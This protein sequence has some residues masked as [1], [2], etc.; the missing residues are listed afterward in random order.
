M[1]DQFTNKVKQNARKAV[2]ISVGAVI[3]LSSYGYNPGGVSLRLKTPSFSSTPQ[4]NGLPAGVSWIKQEG[5]YLKVP[6]LSRTNMFNKNGTLAATSSQDLI[7]TSS[8]V[9][10]PMRQ[11][12]ADSY[13]ME[14]EWSMRYEIPTDDL[15]LEN[16]YQKLKSQEA[17]LGNTMMPFATT[18]FSDS[19]NQMLGEHFAQ[20]GKNLLRSNVTNQAKYGMFVTRVEKGV[21][22]RGTEGVGSN[23]M[24]GGVSTDLEVTKVV[25]IKDENTGKRL[26]SP[27]SI[28]QYGL[29]IVPDSFQLTRAVPIGELAVLI[30]NKQESISRQIKEDER[31][32]ALSKE[33]RSEQLQGEKDLVT[34]TNVLNI[35]KAEAII[36]A[37][38]KV[39]Q[40]RLQAQKETVEREKNAALAVIDKRREQQIAT[41][42]QNIQKANA[43]AAKYEAK[44]IIEVGLAKA[45]VKKADYDAIDKDILYSNNNRDVAIALYESKMVVEMPEYLNV[46]GEAANQTSVENMSTIK[47][48][49]Q[50]RV[51]TAK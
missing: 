10:P 9:V 37:Q 19:V 43:E 29:K 41:A 38:Q 49:E 45:R 1:L 12:F 36:A 34:R 25:Y 20:G 2:I 4:E 23:K 27:L 22:K 8:A 24:I 6:F 30:Q 7:E 46:G 13:E 3:A 50:L 26:R 11:T 42:N 35:K 33:A 16:M 44:A 51:N 40:A 48:M 47:F 18:M 5:Y 17:L 14:F 39:E 15:G 31:Q 21:E 28:A 32:K